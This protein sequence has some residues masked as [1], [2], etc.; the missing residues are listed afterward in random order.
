LRPETL[1]DLKIGKHES[2]ARIGK[3]STEAGDAEGLTGS[4]SDE[5]VDVSKSKRPSC[6]GGHVSE[7]RHIGKA[8]R[9]DC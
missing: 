7:V 6:M 5:D 3:S 2:S 8:M 9:E 4:S 1:S